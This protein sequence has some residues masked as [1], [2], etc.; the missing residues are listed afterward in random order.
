MNG[1]Y[2]S[3][4]AAWVILDILKNASGPM[5]RDDIWLLSGRGYSSIANQMLKMLRH[6]DLEQ[7]G[8]RYDPTNYPDRGGPPKKLWQLPDQ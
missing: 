3:H 5:T 2:R 1:K 4:A 8:T 7:V 6:N